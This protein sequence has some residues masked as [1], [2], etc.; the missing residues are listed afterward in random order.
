MRHDIYGFISTKNGAMANH[1]KGFSDQCFLVALGKASARFLPIAAPIYHILWMFF[2][3]G[4]LTQAKI[5]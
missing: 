5:V 3:A 2:V 4:R 1:I